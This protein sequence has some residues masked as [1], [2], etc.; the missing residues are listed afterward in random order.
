MKL[1]PEFYDTTSTLL[2]FL[3]TAHVAFKILDRR[4]LPMCLTPCSLWSDMSL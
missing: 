4:K 1:D 3:V 2:S